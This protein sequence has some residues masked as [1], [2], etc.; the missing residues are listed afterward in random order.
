[1][2]LTIE[3][4]PEHIGNLIS[5]KLTGSPAYIKQVVTEYQDQKLF[6]VGN[7]KAPIGTVAN[8]WSELVR[9]CNAEDA[10]MQVYLLLD[11]E[12]AMLLRLSNDVR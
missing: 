6:F 12:Q 5:F 7:S 1:M 4:G 8:N 11:S 3:K 10:T 2:K 9:C